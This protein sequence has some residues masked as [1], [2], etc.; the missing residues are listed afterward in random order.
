MVIDYV[1]FVLTFGWR[2]VGPRELNANGILLAKPPSPVG[3]RPT[4]GT[5]REFAKNR[6]LITAYRDKAIRFSLPGRPLAETEL[7]R[8]KTVVASE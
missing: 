4:D 1:F 6:V 2:I 8:V 7:A 5:H 3:S